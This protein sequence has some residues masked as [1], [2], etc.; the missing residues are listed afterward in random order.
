MDVVEV[1]Q[2]SFMSRY[3]SAAAKLFWTISAV[4]RTVLPWLVV[5]GVPLL[6]LI[7]Y[8]GSHAYA[9]DFRAFY[10]AGHDYL[11]GRSPYGSSSLANLTSQ[12]NF[13]YPL[14]AAAAFAP[15]SLLP[16]SIAAALFIG[17]SIVFL[18]AALWLTDVRD[19]RC[20]AAAMVGLP[21]LT[22]LLFGTL[23]PLLALLLAIVWRF[24]D[25]GRAA[26]FALA[27]LVLLKVFLWPLAILFLARRQWRVVAG[28]IAI[29]VTAVLVSA[30]PVGLAPLRDYPGLLRAVSNFEAPLSFSIFSAASSLGVGQIA[31]T[32]VS[33]LVG[34]TLVVLGVRAGRRGD[35]SLAFRALV[36]AAF[37]LSPIVWPHYLVLLFVPLALTR[38]R[39]SPMWLGLAWLGANGFALDR[40]QFAVTI[41]V[42]VVS[43]L[44]T[45]LVRVPQL[46]RRLAET[47][48]YMAVV[49]ATVI[50]FVIGAAARPVVAALR[51]PPGPASGASGSALLR[52]AGGASHTC[53]RVW[54][55][56]IPRGSYATLTGPLGDGISLAGL[57]TDGRSDL[58][59]RVGART[60]RIFSQAVARNPA[61]LTLAVI[62]PSGRVVLSGRP[63]KL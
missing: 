1:A 23:S 31:A 37:A 25:R 22:G 47:A 11:H 43:A 4:A 18:C 33:S 46:P 7:A 16:F 41:A 19:V 14:P 63:R 52:F 20:Y 3:S 54:T 39:Y 15:L 56:G 49:V 62:A 12:Q 34:G 29:G 28:A 59:A 24:R 51:P 57:A 10:N 5:L 53:I 26:T 27:A 9:T 35:D 48:A 42:I 45:G 17:A 21:T 58:C 13:V 6:V 38:P 36:A 61:L 55:S 44:Q 2:V 60:A 32:L 40:W 8:R 30:I 50:L